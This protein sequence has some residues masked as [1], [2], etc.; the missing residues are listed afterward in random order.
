M[1]AIVAAPYGLGVARKDADFVQARAL[2]EILF[3]DLCNSLNQHHGV[4]HSERFWR[5]VLGHWL[6]RYVDVV[7]NRFKTLEQCLSTYQIS[8]ISSYEQDGYSLA[9][10]DSYSA[11]WAF[12][13][14]RWN[15]ELNIRILDLLGID[16][17]DRNIVSSC[18]SIGF[19]F[20]PL[21]SSAKHS[22]VRGIV[23]RSIQK[24]MGISDCFVK[25]NDAFIITSYLPK[26]TE[27][28]LQIKL[29]QF[30]QYWVSPK[31]DMS[32]PADSL[33][34]KKLTKGFNKESSFSIENILR[35]LLFEM[36]PVCYLEG[37]EKI[38]QQVKQLNWPKSPKF[39]FTSNNFDTDEIFKLWAASKIERGSKYFT[40]QHGNNYGTYRYMNPSIE[41]LTS[42]K[43][44]TWGWVDNLP[45]HTPSFI[46][47]LPKLKTES[48]N[49]KRHLL[50][51]ELHC[52][53][54]ITLW[55]S[56]SE[57]QKYF[58]EQQSFV[59][60]LH[61][62]LKSQLIIRLHGAH[63]YL[64]WSEMARW[65]SVDPSLHIDD[66]SSNIK[67]LIQNSRLVVHSYDS[68]G[69]LET[70]SQNIPTLA[71]WQNGFD[72]LRDSAKPSYQLLVDAGIVHL[73]PESAAAKVN[74]IWEDVDGWWMQNK[75]Q[76]ARR[77]FCERYARNSQNPTHDL[78]NIFMR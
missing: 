27:I 62:A 13:D 33:L 47:K 10:L 65:K 50:L 17:F 54:R 57:F 41:E 40:G 5:I 9:T 71:F 30:P 61:P 67:N 69:I 24:I 44:L 25:D 6:R 73:S 23:K 45:Q 26:D 18:T 28:N 36:I 34:R 58:D 31:L 66:G 21:K 42:D 76:I 59:H 51:S 8:G 74:E 77:I 14:D 38:N 22:L 43:F 63:R 16:Y 48:H 29:G 4:S 1:D 35:K 70:L 20:I 53:R 78:K 11:I 3:R 46:I 64:K 2:E 37:F 15:V 49:I 39:I 55:D 60:L 52:N 12:D 56:I 19:R 72:H 75:I 68:T 7:F 32:V